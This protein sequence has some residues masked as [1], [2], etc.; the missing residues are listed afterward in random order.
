MLN[1]T[2]SKTTVEK[3]VSKYVLKV[4]IKKLKYATRVH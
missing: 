3:S 4:N 2:I 1:V